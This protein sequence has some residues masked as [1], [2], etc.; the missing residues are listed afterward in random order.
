MYVLSVAQVST[1]M[2]YTGSALPLQKFFFFDVVLD[3]DEDVVV[4][5]LELDE[6]DDDV[7]VVLVVLVDVEDAVLVVEVEVDVVIVVDV[8]DE[9]VEVKS[10]Q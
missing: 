10:G 7:E 9:V 2:Q 4:D 6:L 3:V 8:V 1:F 5:E